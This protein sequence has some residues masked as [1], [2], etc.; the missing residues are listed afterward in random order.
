MKLQLLDL[1]NNCVQLQTLSKL[2]HLRATF[3][4]MWFL[5]TLAS[6]RR[7]LYIYNSIRKCMEMLGSLLCFTLAWIDFHLGETYL[8]FVVVKWWILLE[9]LSITGSWAQQ[10]SAQNQLCNE[11]GCFLQRSPWCHV[12]AQQPCFCVPTLPTVIQHQSTL[13]AGASELR[14][15]YTTSCG[16]LCSLYAQSSWL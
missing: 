5:E 3:L 13:P 8:G 2:F 10:N 4:L 6:A 11:P 12:T 9:L 1:P 15:F 14:P 7:V 16:V